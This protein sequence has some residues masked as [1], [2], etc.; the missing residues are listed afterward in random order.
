MLDAAE[1]EVFVPLTLSFSVLRLS[2]VRD[3]AKKKRLRSALDVDAP[4][5]LK[6]ASIANDPTLCH[7]AEK[8]R[9]FS[10]NVGKLQV[11]KK[12]QPGERCAVVVV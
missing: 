9:L 12:P 10:H 4:D 2:V 8:T 3:G 6:R 11:A 5:L 1:E 7:H